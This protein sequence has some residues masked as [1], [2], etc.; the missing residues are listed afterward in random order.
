LQGQLCRVQVHIGLQS[1]GQFSTQINRAL[2]NRL[3]EGKCV[4]VDQVARCK[5]DTVDDLLK[6]LPMLWSKTQLQLVQLISLAARRDRN[7]SP[8]QDLE[9]LQSF[10]MMHVLR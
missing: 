2:G 9:R 5:V 3:L 4:P 7:Q 1:P 8:L 10:Q 6:L